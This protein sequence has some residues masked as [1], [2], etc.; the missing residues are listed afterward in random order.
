[1]TKEDVLELTGLITK[2]PDH[3]RAVTKRET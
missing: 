1:V 2:V 3:I